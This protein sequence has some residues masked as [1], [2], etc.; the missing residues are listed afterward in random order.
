[1]SS[2]IGREHGVTT[3]EK[4]DRKSFFPMLLK[5]YHH[6]HPLSKF[7]HSF[8]K[9]SDEDYNLDIFEMVTSMSELIKD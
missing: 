9:R 8:A 1:M 7:E 4:Y 3:T 2:F 5:S 6:L